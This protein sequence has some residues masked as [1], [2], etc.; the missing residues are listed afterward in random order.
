MDAPAALAPALEALKGAPLFAPV[1]DDELRALASVLESR[2]FASGA[3]IMREGESASE[4][5]I[6]R[7]GSARVTG[8][9]LAGQTVTLATLA[10]GAV[11]GEIGLLRDVPRTATV[12]A[13]GDVDAF[14]LTRAAF[15]RLTDACAVATAHLRQRADMLDLDSFVRRAS[16]FA[17]LPAAAVHA[18]AGSLVRVHKQQSE[19]VVLEGEA[20]DY[21]YM[22]RSGQLEVSRRGHRL[23]VLQDGDCFGEVALVAAQARTATVRALTDADLFALDRERFDAI[24]AEYPEAR[25]FVTE[26]VR[27]RSGHKVAAS[28]LT[29]KP[30][31]GIEAGSKFLNSRPKY[32]WLVLAI[33]VLTY[34]GLCFWALNTGDFL[35]AGAAM[36]E[37]SLLGPVTYVIYLAECDVLTQRI[38][39]LAVT[40]ALGAALGVPV[41][42]QLESWVGLTALGLT[43]AVILACIEEPAKLLGVVWVLWRPSARFRMDGIIYG[44]AAGMGFA[45]LE[46]V[47]YG[48]DRIEFFGTLLTTISYRT[49]LAPFGHGMWTAIICACIWQVKGSGRPRLGWPILGG[50]AISVT[51]HTLWDSQIVTGGPYLLWVLLLGAAGILVLRM[52]LRRATAEEQSAALALNPELADAAHATGTRLHCRNCGQLGPPGTH[53]CVRCGLALTAATS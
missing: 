31:H 4:L 28:G 27:I 50:L 16:P 29:A 42:V 5:L 43:T 21:F 11:L 45:A 13:E 7:S 40:F 44:A 34:A 3:L 8:R 20:G 46:N 33:G 1:P 49:L 32:V 12:V 18:L 2:T 39:T 23:Q 6:L 30:T 15:E 17:H 47:R 25:S 14:V 41:A 19:A 36:V 24:V 38:S 26:L 51:L 22:V 48:L 37:G 53:Y 35:I 52:L 9:D 10:P